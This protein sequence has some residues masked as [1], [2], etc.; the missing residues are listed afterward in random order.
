MTAIKGQTGPATMSAWNTNRSQNLQKLIDLMP[1]AAGA[2][3]V[4]AVAI[5]ALKV[6]VI[7]D[8]GV[9]P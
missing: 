9:R 6:K 8:V 3:D 4:G 1:P 2:M 7:V 5:T